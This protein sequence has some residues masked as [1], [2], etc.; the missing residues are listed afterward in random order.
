MLGKVTVNGH[1]I[2]FLVRFAF[3]NR[4]ALFLSTHPPTPIRQTVADGYSAL[5][6]FCVTCPYA[7]AIRVIIYSKIPHHA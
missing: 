4:D 7:S 2:K 3:C 5:V 1:V 6:D